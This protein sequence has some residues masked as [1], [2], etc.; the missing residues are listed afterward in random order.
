[1][2]ILPHLSETPNFSSGI[3]LTSFSITGATGLFSSLLTQNGWCHLQ[4]SAIQGLFIGRSGS[5]RLSISSSYYQTGH[6]SS[7]VLYS[8]FSVMGAH[9][10]AKLF[11]LVLGSPETFIFQL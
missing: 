10:S 1:M 9:Y 7:H 3:T 2:A 5:P 8:K 11:L 6:W 4:S